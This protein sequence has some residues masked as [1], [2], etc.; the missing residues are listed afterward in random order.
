MMARRIATT[1]ATTESIGTE[2]FLECAAA[3]A[4]PMSVMQAGA[5][6]S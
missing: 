3:D 6:G 5:G 1:A 4:A 2:R